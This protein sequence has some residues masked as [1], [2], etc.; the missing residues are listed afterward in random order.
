MDAA[1]CAAHRFVAE[2]GRKRT[3]ADGPGSKGYI[4]DERYPIAT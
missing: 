4:T 1:F 3:E 2:D